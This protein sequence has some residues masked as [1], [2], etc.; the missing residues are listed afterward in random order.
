MSYSAF[1]GVDVSAES[2]HVVYIT[3]EGEIGEP[4]VISQTRS[5]MGALQKSLLAT[6][7]Q[8]ARILVVMEAT[9]VYWMK[10]AVFLHAAGFAVSVINP[11]Q[12]HYFAR[13]LL[14]RSKTDRIDARLLAQLAAKLQPEPWQPLSETYEELYQRLTQREALFH[15]LQQERNRLH[16]VRQR[17]QT[18]TD[19]AV[20]LEAHIGFLQ[21]QIAE[22]DEEFKR[23]LAQD[24]AWART[25]GLLRSIKGFGPVA[26]FW[27]LTATH[28]FTAC[29]SPEQVASYAGLVPRQFESGSS[30]RGRP[31]IGHAPHARLRQALYMACL[32]AVQHNPIIKAFYQ[33]LLDRGKPKKV[34]LCACARKLIHIAWAVVTKE[35]SFDPRHALIDA[36]SFA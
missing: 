23:V 26:T 24:K 28:N 4:F 14:Q 1:V 5:G 33:R 11:A 20:R 6:G 3:S 30:V 7:Y 17:P 2:A 22:I 27:L 31:T 35:C 29:T 10:L 16:A 8:V 19:V 15:M 25:A 32:S 34:A 12:A 9:G 18:V 21:A 36:E 13:A